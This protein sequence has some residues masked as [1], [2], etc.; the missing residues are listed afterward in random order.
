MVGLRLVHPRQLVR[1]CATVFECGVVVLPAA[2]KQAPRK[3]IP[4]S[5]TAHTV[6][7]TDGR[8]DAASAASKRAARWGL[9]GCIA[10]TRGMVSCTVRVRRARQVGRRVQ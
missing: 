3:R 5:P 10:P 6:L 4:R 8:E 2:A 7:F 1:K 9:P